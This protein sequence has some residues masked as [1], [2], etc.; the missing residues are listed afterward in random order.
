MFSFAINVVFS[1]ALA[2]LLGMIN[3]LQI[4]FHLPILHVVMPGNVQ[5]LFQIMV[6][7]VMFDI[8][9]NF[10]LIQNLFPDSEF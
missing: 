8:L 6:P 3:S 9:E 10:E 2:L 7:V 1:Q 5:T 4:I